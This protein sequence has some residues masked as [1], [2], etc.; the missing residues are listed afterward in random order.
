MKKQTQP[1]FILAE[2]QFTTGILLVRYGV[3]IQGKRVQATIL[4]V[5]YSSSPTENTYFYKF[6]NNNQ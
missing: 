4:S 2:S 1:Q 5:G 3:N 6:Y